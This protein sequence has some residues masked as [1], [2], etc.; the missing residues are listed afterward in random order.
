[1]VL[2]LIYLFLIVNTKFICFQLTFAY[3][4]YAQETPPL[5][6]IKN[7]NLLLASF[8]NNVMIAR[9]AEKYS[10]H[11]IENPL[12]LLLLLGPCCPS[13]SLPAC[14][15]QTGGICLWISNWPIAIATNNI[16]NNIALVQVHV[17]WI[18]L[19]KS[20]DG[21][22]G[23]GLWPFSIWPTELYWMTTDP[24]PYHI[25]NNNNN[26]TIYPPPLCSFTTSFTSYT[27][28]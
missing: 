16:N 23:G 10:Q 5:N 25:I 27:Y 14:R 18:S 1:M 3:T 28:I 6:Q 9:V 20:T 11:C 13:P 7:K 21:G 24:P 22:G 12:L 8:I 4:I 2:F 26:R 19:Y 15:A 17:Q